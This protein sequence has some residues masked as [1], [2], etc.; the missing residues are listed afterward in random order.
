MFEV[1]RDPALYA[2]LDDAPPASAEALRALY[3]RHESG[4]SPDGLQ[5]WLNWIVQEPNGPPAG[6]VQATVV[7]GGKAWIGY[8]L[9]SSYRG[10]GLAAAAVEAMLRHLAQACGVD[11]ALAMVEAANAGSLRLL[12][13]LNFRPASPAEIAGH[14]LSPSERLFIRQLRSPA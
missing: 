13:R 4:T 9:G 2:W 3:A 8:V 7:A 10:R 1:L 12:E 11:A 6:Y 14:R 5:L